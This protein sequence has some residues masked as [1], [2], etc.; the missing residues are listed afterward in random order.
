MDAQSQSPDGVQRRNSL[1]E[2]FMARLH[3][4]SHHDA[5]RAECWG[6]AGIAPPLDT[7]TPVVHLTCVVADIVSFVSTLSTTEPPHRHRPHGPQ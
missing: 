2:V 1:A 6:Q 5:P 4:M 7:L 3:F